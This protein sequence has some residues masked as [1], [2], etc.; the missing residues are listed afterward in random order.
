MTAQNIN[1]LRPLHNVA[2]ADKTRQ[3]ERSVDTALAGPKGF[4][5]NQRNSGVSVP[6]LLGITGVNE[7]IESIFDDVLLSA[8]VL[9]QPLYGHY[10]CK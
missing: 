9:R 4:N 5:K 2:N 3:P 7:H 10:W 8:V 6:L 1:T